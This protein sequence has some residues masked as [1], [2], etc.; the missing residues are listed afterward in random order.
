MTVSIIECMAVAERTGFVLRQYINEGEGD[1]W[2]EKLAAR[3]A[4]YREAREAL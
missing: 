4:V 3:E 2:R 1:T